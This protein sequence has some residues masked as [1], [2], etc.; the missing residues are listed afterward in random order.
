MTAVATDLRSRAEAVI[1]AIADRLA[2]PAKVAATMV[3]ADEA[4]GSGQ[5]RW[6]PQS[7]TDGFPATALLFA[8][9]AHTDSGYR[10]VAHSHLAAGAAATGIPVHGLYIG[11]GALG[12]AAARAA[13]KPGEYGGLLTT[14]DEQL[15]T[16][17]RRRL[18]PEWERIAA[19]RAGTAFSAYDVVTGVTGVG[20]HLL[21]RDD[22]AAREILRYLV[23]LTKPVGDLP[24]W[25]VGH[26]PTMGDSDGHANAGLA[27]GIAGPLALLSVAW[28]AG[29]RVPGQ[30]E[31]IDRIV[32]WLLDWSDTD[33]HGR[34]W[35]DGLSRADLRERPAV[36]APARSAW[37]YGTP[38]VAT[39]LDL[40]GAAL[41]LPQWRAT[42]LDAVLAMLRRPLHSHGVVDAGLCH[43]WGGLLHL[44]SRMGRESGS[45]ELL[46]AADRLAARVI[47]SYDPVRPFGFQA[48]AGDSRDD[49]AGFME[50]AAGVALALHG[51]LTAPAS[52]WDA[53]LLAA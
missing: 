47:E 36:L 30:D 35:P 6:V 45:T 44:T 29:V 39:A 17:V 51:W 37:C 49:V 4:R 23:T 26:S 52:G 42:A 34:Y 8:E 50:G 7:L 16:W 3:A 2:D 27:H 21:G 13:R 15:A 33:E 40:A 28:R 1:A 18:E 9:L 38:G 43:G 24:G 25:W 48:A 41:E 32:R 12:F 46:A 5:E 53:A 31:A 20:R 22:Q 10:R 19:G 11:P 14:V